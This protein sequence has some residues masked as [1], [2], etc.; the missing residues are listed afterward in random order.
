MNFLRCIQNVYASI[1]RGNTILLLQLG[2]DHMRLA[3]IDSKARGV[4][5]LGSVETCADGWSAPT[6]LAAVADY[7]PEELE[8]G[9]RVVYILEDDLVYKEK[10][11]LPRLNRKELACAL[12]WEAASYSDDCV[13]DGIA[14]CDIAGS[15]EQE[16]SE[17]IGEIYFFAA[18]RA[19]IEDLH[20]ISIALDLRTWGI[21][22]AC[23]GAEQELLEERYKYSEEE[24]KDLLT[25][26]AQSAW[27]AEQ[28]HAGLPLPNF[29][30]FVKQK[31]LRRYLLS[32]AAAGCAFLYLAVGGWYG[33][34]MSERIDMERKTAELRSMMQN[35]SIW[36][37]RIKQEKREVAMISAWENLSATDKEVLM[38]SRELSS[39]GMV[40]GKCILEEVERKQDSTDVLLRGYGENMESVMALV[41]GLAENGI[42]GDVHI[43]EAD[44]V[45]GAKI[46]FKIKATYSKENK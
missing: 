11:T 34:L 5:P 27:V 25:E 45:K 1:C 2:K 39:W 35:Y 15:C 40:D 17:S 13:Y 28:L 37:D 8:D 20:E 9:C 19:L 10:L 36:V 21:T 14:A 30:K 16:K 43:A 18:K 44:T 7:L 6:S 22:A 12:Q 31:E 23:L 46:G 33:W 24:F 3:L 29:L 4:I 38:F 32:S 41:G 26:Y 42:Y